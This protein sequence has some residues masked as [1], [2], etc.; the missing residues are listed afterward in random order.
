M[1]ASVHAVAFA[2]CLL[3]ALP[4]CAKE[5]PLWEGLTKTPEMLAA[6]AAFVASVKDATGGDFKAGYQRVVRKGWDAFLAGDQEI[7]IKRFNQATL[8]DPARG[9]AYWGFALATHVR[10]DGLAVAERWFLE[11]EKRIPEEP[12]LLA[13]HARTLDESGEPERAKVMFEHVVEL[14]PTMPVGHIGLSRVLYQLGDL[15]GAR[16]HAEEAERLL[17]Q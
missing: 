15:E 7:A 9:E 12:A 10:G 3:M 8:I 2:F 1:R 11:A 17:A 5:M 16:K 13:D 4:S 14:A 6:D